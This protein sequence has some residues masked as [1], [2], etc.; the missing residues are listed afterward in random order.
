MLARPPQVKRTYS[1]IKL[2]TTTEASTTD[3]AEC[4]SSE[5]VEILK[6]PKMSKITDFFK[7]REFEQEKDDNHRENGENGE[8]III[9]REN[10][11]NTAHTNANANTAHTNRSQQQQTFLDL[12][13]KN[14]VSSQCPECLMHF[15]KSFPEDVSLHKKFHSQYLKGFTFRYNPQKDAKSVREI[16]PDNLLKWSKYRF[17][18][19]GDL[20][21][22]HRLLKRLAFFMEFVHV[23]LGAEPLDF[24]ELIRTE[25]D[26]S[27]G[28]Y[29]VILTT[30]HLTSKIVGFCL[31][32]KC[33]RV[34][35]SVL[36]CDAS[37]IEL[38]PQHNQQEGPV[39]GVSRIWVDPKHRKRNLAST[40]LDLKSSSK[41]NLIAFSQPT[42]MGFSFA[43]KYQRSP[44]CFI[45]LE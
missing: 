27:T 44:Q 7:T 19:I 29:S 10:I 3:S 40:I 17:Y 9:N 24:N 22:N 12:G 21:H 5:N 23:Q 8:N 37:A 26:S 28:H 15:N 38:E 35:K 13:Q 32:E 33:K 11:L 25:Q 41:R 34:F 16:A 30:D 39:Y 43:K 18:D 31:F 36:D 20:S 42:P 14:L 4:E 45:Y 6:A 1:R 2:Q